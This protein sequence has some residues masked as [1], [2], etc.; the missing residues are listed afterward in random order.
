MS[1]HIDTEGYQKCFRYK[2]QPQCPY[3][4]IG[5]D[6]ADDG[7]HEIVPYYECKSIP[8]M[9]GVEILLRAILDKQTP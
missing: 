9:Y 7:S 6:F 2:E 4:V 5:K 3:L 8:C 1:M